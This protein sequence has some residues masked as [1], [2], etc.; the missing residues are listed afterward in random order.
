GVII[1]QD[2]AFYGCKS[3]ES[4]DIEAA[5]MGASAFSGCVGLK[6]V[7]FG[8]TYDI[9]SNAF[10]RCSF[11][12]E[13]G[14][15]RLDPVAE[16]LSGSAFSGV[17]SK[18]VREVAVGDRFVYGD[19][20]YT[21][22]SVEGLTVEVDV[23]N[24]VKDCDV[25]PEVVYL[26]KEYTVTSMNTDGLPQCETITLPP[27]LTVINGKMEQKKLVTLILGSDVS[28][29]DQWHNE[30][31]IKTPAYGTLYHQATMSAGMYWAHTPGG[32]LQY[33]SP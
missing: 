27:T 22:T 29:T 31:R 5:Y 30:L 20:G 8:E 16:N 33:V 6:H 7:A 13:T 26:G 15:V 4:L 17:Y 23:F 9:G 1:I 25:P 32:D 11:Y 18:L 12:D 21:V 19:Y 10:Y 3:I 2:Y 24:V 14:T 28:F